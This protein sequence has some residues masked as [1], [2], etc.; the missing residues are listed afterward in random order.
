[1]IRSFVASVDRKHVTRSAIAL[2][3]IAVFF[4]AAPAQAQPCPGTQ[5]APGGR[6]ASMGSSGTTTGPLFS[7]YGTGCVSA[8]SGAATGC[9]KNKTASSVFLTAQW[10]SAAARTGDATGGCVFTCQ[11]G[12]CRIG[13]DGLP[14]ELLQFGVE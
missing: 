2:T 13:S 12:S 11:N 9:L 5:G 10:P 6:F 1:M 8:F 4:Q 14:V 7:L 3:A